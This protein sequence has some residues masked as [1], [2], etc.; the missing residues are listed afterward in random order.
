M[1]TV[2]FAP[3]MSSSTHAAAASASAISA[4]VRSPSGVRTAMNAFSGRPSRSN[5]TVHD[6]TVPVPS[7]STSAVRVGSR[8]TALWTFSQRNPSAGGTVL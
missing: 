6:S 4:Q 5:G 1:E 7:H 8:S 2:T 3:A